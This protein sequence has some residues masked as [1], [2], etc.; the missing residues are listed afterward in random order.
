[1]LDG[2]PAPPPLKGHTPQFSANICCGQTAGW[3]K[4][5]LG[6]EVGLG[7]GDFVFDGD[8]ATPRKRVHP[9]HPIFGLCL[10]WPNGWR[11]Q[12]ITWYGGKCRFRRRRLRWGRR[13]PI[14]VAQPPVFV[15]CLLWLNGWMDDDATWYGSRP[16][17]RPHCIRRGPSSPRKGHS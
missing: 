12:D 1:V 6:I 10:L 13:S 3:T 4:L 14:K 7:P 15:S 11:D 2:D 5:A 8:P 16:R 9:P 17:P